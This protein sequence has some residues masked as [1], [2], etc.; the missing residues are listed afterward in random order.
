MIESQLQFYREKD[1]TRRAAFQIIGDVR[2][3]ITP[4]LSTSYESMLLT[5]SVLTAKAYWQRG[6][7][8]SL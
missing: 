8:N 4:A 1:V 7:V 5:A 2:G 3:L 6:K